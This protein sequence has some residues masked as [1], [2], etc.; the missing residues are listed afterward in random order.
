VKLKLAAFA[1]VSLAV[2]F[3]IQVSAAPATN[4]ILI[5]SNSDFTFVGTGGGC[6]CVAGGHGTASDPWM[7]QNITVNADKSPGVSI[8]GV[9]DSFVLS[10]L[11]IHTTDKAP[12]ILL[13]SLTTQSEVIRITQVNIDS[14]GTAALHGDAPG[15]G[16]HLQDTSNVTIDGNSINTLSGWGIRVDG[17][18]NN[19]IR[20]MTVTHTGLA[21]PASKDTAVLFGSPGNPWLT[22]VTGDAVGGVLLNNTS[23]NYVHDDLL[24]E[25]GYVGIELVNSKA[26]TLDK[27]NVRY[28]DYFGAY[29]QGSSNN[30][31]TNVSLQTADFDGL[32]VRA[33]NNNTIKFDTFSANGPIGNEWAADIVPYF[34][35][36]AYVGWGSGGNIIEANNGNF[37]NTGPDLE[38]DD[39]FVPTPTASVQG[40]VVQSFNPLNTSTGDDPGGSVL[41]GSGN[42]VCGNSFATNYWFPSNLKANGPCQ[43]S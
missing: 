33:S 11:N 19:I 8:S 20:F 27:I 16:I 40:G 34:V 13:R 26:N 38:L 32:L 10:H 17:G 23:N 37:G 15:M 39:G 21:N 7:I 2:S 9:T 1:V 14:P 31:L 24:N 30:T 41:V 25:D 42:V 35:A 3:A 4:P 18:S 29:L 22:G 5:G 36:G 12:G 43:T 6:G 28:P